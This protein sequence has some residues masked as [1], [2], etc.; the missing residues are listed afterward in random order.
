M[1]TANQLYFRLGRW[2]GFLSCACVMSS[3]MAIPAFAAIGSKTIAVRILVDEEEPRRDELWKET[4]GKR[5]DKASTILSGYGS[6]RFS[7]TKFGTWDSNDSTV[8]FNASLREFEKEANP[9]PAELAIGFTS[10]YRLK[11]GVSNLGGTRGPM[12]RHILIREGAP[13]VQEVE[14]LEVLVHELAHYLG[15]AHSGDMSSVMRPALGDGRSRAKSFRIQLDFPNATIVRLV[16][17]EMAI[18]NVTRMDQLSVATQRA[19]RNQYALLSRT[20]PDDHV[21]GHYVLVMD[22]L[23]QRSLARERSRATARR[24]AK[25]PISVRPTNPTTIGAGETPE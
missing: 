19:I 25:P 5:L 2:L 6:I 22:K 18:R 4:L 17:G 10:Q 16:S 1:I 13:K 9:A 15:A 8:D 7:V 20:F 14:R 21:A 12:R 24:S 23:I 3:G 11:R